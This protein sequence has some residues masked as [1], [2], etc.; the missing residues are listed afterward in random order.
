MVLSIAPLRVERVELERELVGLRAV[1]RCQEC[2]ARARR[3]DA[4]RRVEPWREQEAEMARRDFLVLEP[5]DLDERRDARQCSRLHAG[6]ALL[7]DT[8]V[9]PAQRHDVCDRAE[10]DELEVIRGGRLAVPR[11]PR[12][13]SGKGLAELKGH[14]DA[15]EVLVRI[16]AVRAMRVEHRTGGRQLAA[17]QMVVRDDDVELASA[18][19]R[20]N[21]R[22]RSDAAVH[23]DEQVRLL[24][25]L[26]ERPAVEAV[27]LRHAVGDVEVH[28]RAE[29]AQR[30]RQERRRRH[31]VDIVV[32]VDRDVLPLLQRP[33]NARDG[34]VHVAHRK[35]ISK[36]Q[37]LWMQKKFRFLARADAA[38]PEERRHRRIPANLP[39][40]RR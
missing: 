7:D 36:R 29:F 12:P 37:P 18:L 14:A 38:V 30:P 19:Y 6:H 23:R 26:L 34:L 15:R 13:R 21:I 8:A 3:L 17:R 9:L 27:A 2:D 32:A 40:K 10:R 20:R 39:R 24:R 22:D 33:H 5:R 25:N 28:L 11:L 4:P 31:A 35:R 16:R 1:F